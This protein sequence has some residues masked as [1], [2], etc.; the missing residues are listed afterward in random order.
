MFVSCK[1]ASKNAE[2]AVETIE[3]AVETADSL[4]TEFVEAV[5]STVV[6]E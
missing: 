6:A 1:N 3:N 2:E 4:A 5:D